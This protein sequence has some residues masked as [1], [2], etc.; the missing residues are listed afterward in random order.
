V[1][2]LLSGHVTYAVAQPSCQVRGRR[3]ARAAA[4]WQ[5][6]HMRPHWA[7]WKRAP[8]TSDEEL[9]L[10]VRLHAPV[11]VYD[12]EWAVRILIDGPA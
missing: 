10:G 1:G 2:V 11:W 6:R 5:A 3:A 8:H 12:T 9:G 7:H 4:R